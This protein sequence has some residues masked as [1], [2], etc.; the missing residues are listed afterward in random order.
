MTDSEANGKKLTI[1]TLPEGLL[2]NRTWLN[3][4][5]FSRPG[6]DY[7]LRSGNLEPVYRGLYRKSGAK[8]KW[9]QVAFSLQEMGY[10]SHI[11]GMTALVEKGLGHYIEMGTRDIQV[12]SASKLPKWLAIWQQEQGTDYTFSV[13]VKKW[14]KDL[15]KEFFYTMPFGSWDWPITTS[16]PELAVIEMMS[17]AKSFSDLQ[18]IN[19]IFDGLTTLS[20]NRLQ[21]ILTHCDS[22]QTKRL[23]GWFSDRH[24]HAWVKRIDWDLLNLGKGKRSFIKGGVLNKKWQI[25]VPREME[26]NHQSGDGFESEQPLF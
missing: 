14:I 12:F 6:I 16:Q 5:G 7:Y 18:T 11:G 17:E 22:I 2:V 9:Q 19:S 15:P 25:T 4:K 10:S 8:L 1:K 13:H 23:F 21:L 20:P 26:Q 24:S 3:D